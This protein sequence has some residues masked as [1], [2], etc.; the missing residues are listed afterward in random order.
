[1]LI[2]LGIIPPIDGGLSQRAFNGYSSMPS[3][4]CP[5]V[6]LIPQWQASA[7]NASTR[8]SPIAHRFGEAVSVRFCRRE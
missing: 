7:A 2:A 1:M 8:G 3:L 6:Q 4:D 5:C